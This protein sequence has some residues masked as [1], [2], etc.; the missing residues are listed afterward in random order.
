MSIFDSKSNQIL[1]QW[2]L[3]TFL[4]VLMLWNVIE[5]WM[6]HNFQH[7]RSNIRSLST[8]GKLYKNNSNIIRKREIFSHSIPL[9]S[10]EFS[11]ITRALT[12]IRNPGSWEMWERE[13]ESTK[14]LLSPSHPTNKQGSS[15]KGA[16]ICFGERQ[17]IFRCRNEFEFIFHQKR[18]GFR[19]GPE[20]RI[21]STEN[22]INWVCKRISFVEKK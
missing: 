22:W 8:S 1:S 14:F 5:L 20:E 7:S 17:K 21:R 18:I 19:F 6:F 9:L 16:R 15:R 13:E 2:V 4:N 3:S 10:H 12:S 11:T